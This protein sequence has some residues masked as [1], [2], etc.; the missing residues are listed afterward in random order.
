MKIRKTP[1]MVASMVLAT[2]MLAMT[3]VT[4]AFATENVADVATPTVES[5]QDLT[6]STQTTRVG[7]YTYYAYFTLS[8]WYL[9]KTLHVDT[10]NGYSSAGSVYVHLYNPSGKE[11]SNDWI[12]GLNDSAEWTVWNLP[13]GQ[14]T[15]K[16][17]VIADSDDT[18]INV[19]F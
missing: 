14:Y 9:A 15:C 17:V 4:P 18:Y 8:E 3:S 5:T 6:A 16:F 1:K 7:A 2:A 11:L 10:G 19:T 13:K 12:M